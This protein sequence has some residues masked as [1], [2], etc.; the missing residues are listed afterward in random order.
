MKIAVCVKQVPDATAAKRLDPVTRRLDR[1]GESALNATD[2][3]AVEEALRIKEAA[4]GEVVVV[5]LGPE[6]AL[7]SLRKAL[8]MGADRAVLVS[9]P[10]AAG[11]DLVATSYVLAKALERESADLV[12]FGQQSSDSDG[13]VL[14]AAVAERLRR[15]MVSQVAEL[16][17][18]GGSVTGKRQTEFGYDVISAPLPA[19]VAV[20]DAINEPRYPSLKGIMSAKSKPTETLSL[21]DI[22]VEADRAGAAGSRTTVIALAPPPPKGDQ[23]K[24]EDDG[25]A[26]ERLVEFLAERKLL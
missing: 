9:D 13:A 12:L 2:V 5:S 10:D 14:W 18:D 22:A 6:K 21:A 25:S 15:P 20:S 26:A 4:G 24:L 16:T 19:V 11:S 7:D 17:V 23:I 8:A 3:N 1:S